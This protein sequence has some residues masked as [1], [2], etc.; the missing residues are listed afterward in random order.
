MKKNSSGSLDLINQTESN[1]IGSGVNIERQRSLSQQRFPNLLHY[2]YHKSANSELAQ[3]DSMMSR[4][5]LS[6]L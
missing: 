4:E 3:E 2:F 6:K 5:Q 1:Q